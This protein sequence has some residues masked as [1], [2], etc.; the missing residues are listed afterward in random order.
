MSKSPVFI[1]SSRF[2]RTDVA[3]GPT[4][5]SKNVSVNFAAIHPDSNPE[6]PVLTGAGEF[7]LSFDGDN[8]GAADGFELGR[9]Y[10]LVPV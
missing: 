6:R 8:A 10:R 3:V 9:L 4:R 1:C 2:S 5:A 7:C